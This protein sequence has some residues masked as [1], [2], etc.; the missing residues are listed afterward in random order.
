MIVRKKGKSNE[1]IVV[2]AHYDKVSDGCGAIDN[3][4]G[5]VIIAHLYRTIIQTQTEKSY[6]FAAFDK[7][8]VGLLGSDAMVKA[9]PKK[10]SQYCAMISL[11]SFG[12]AIPQVLDNV[13]SAELVAIAQDTA[14]KLKMP[15]AK[16]SLLADADSSSFKKRNIPAIT[17]HGLSDSWQKYLHTNRDKLENVNMSSVY[18]GYLFTLNFISTLDKTTCARTSKH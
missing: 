9:I 1:T 17:F 10:R 11:D 16:A 2:G 14:K 6:V 4:T 18:Y 15:F 3:W 8:E 12:L 7:E 5:L 13:S